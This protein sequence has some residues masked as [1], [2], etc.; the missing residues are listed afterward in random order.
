MEP[1]SAGESKLKWTVWVGLAVAYVPSGTAQLIVIQPKPYQRELWQL[2][3]RKVLKE[4]F[5]KEL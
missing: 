1:G 3:I 2:A 5:T 4:L